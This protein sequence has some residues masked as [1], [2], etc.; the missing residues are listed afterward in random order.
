MV[1]LRKTGRLFSS[2]GLVSVV[3]LASAGVLPLK[4][5]EIDSA[6]TAE[7]D[8]PADAPT[9][10][11][12]P[13]LEG[14]Q[15]YVLPRA[16]SLQIPEGW[17]ASGSASDRYAV[18]TNYAP[19][20]RVGTPQAGDI[21]TEVRFVS[22]PPETFVD[23]SIGEIVANQYEVSYFR[24]TVVD[25]LPALRLWMT[26]LPLEYPNQVVTYVGYASYGTAVITSHYVDATPE[27]DA[28]I[29]QIHNTFTLVFQ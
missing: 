20:N 17:V 4:A 8:A 5:D 16:F 14:F 23:Q 18:I 3:G 2:L 21:K 25:D 22:Q 12:E 10:S 6:P 7:V 9:D 24:A 15:T 26:D 1:N 28:L 13:G 19:R 29:Q 11:V 27:T